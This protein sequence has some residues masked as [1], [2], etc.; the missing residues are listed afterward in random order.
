[1]STVAEFLNKKQAKSRYP[2]YHLPLATT[3]CGVEL[4]VDDPNGREPLLFPHRQQ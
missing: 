3:L 4:E 1:M 2:K